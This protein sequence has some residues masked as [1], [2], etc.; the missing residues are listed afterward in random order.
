MRA[1]VNVADRHFVRGSARMREALTKYGAGAEF[2]AWI[3]R[4]PEGSP[5]HK[6]F[7]YAFKAW[8]ILAAAERGF[9]SILWMDSSILPIRDMEP[10]WEKIERDGYFLGNNGWSNGQW[11]PDA[12]Y[13][14]LDIS[15][16]ENWKVKHCVAGVIG[17]DLRHAIAV[18]FASEYQR[19]STTE[20]FRGP[21]WN[22]NHPQHGK[23]PGAAPCGPPEVMGA[24]HD[25]TAASVIAHKLGM[26]LTDPPEFFCY[27]GGETERTVIVADGSY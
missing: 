9:S 26:E 12:A 19:L 7:P 2:L 17:L 23:R 18:D 22:A 11:T 10:L 21:V 20:A 5:P 6:A 3:N 24:R 15:R 16:E 8:A 13:P 14:A 27:R 4:L 1:V 25:Q